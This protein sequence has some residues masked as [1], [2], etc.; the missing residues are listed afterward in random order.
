LRANCMA[1][2]LIIFLFLKSAANEYIIM[3]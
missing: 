1:S 3:S 2:A